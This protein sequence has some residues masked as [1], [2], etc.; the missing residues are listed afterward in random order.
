MTTVLWGVHRVV[1][2]QFHAKMGKT[3]FQL[4][5]VELKRGLCNET[6]IPVFILGTQLHIT[7]PTQHAAWLCP[8]K[9]GTCQPWLDG[10]LIARFTLG[11]PSRPR[12]GDDPL[13]LRMLSSLC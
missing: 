8:A 4:S 13:D 5:S 12:P 6:W 3:T 11:L 7:S 2:F 10:Q 9:G 1:N